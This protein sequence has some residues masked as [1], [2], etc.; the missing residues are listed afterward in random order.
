M[1]GR[2]KKPARSADAPDTALL[3]GLDHLDQGVLVIGADL[4]VRAGNRILYDIYEF[5]EGF[6][7]IGMPMA[8]VFRFLALRGD[9]GPGDPDEITENML[10]L[11]RHGR[12]FNT[13]IR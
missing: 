2:D 8:D 4:M 9:Y 6:I 7:R 11:I 5:P 1:T 10:D 3:S 12:R 13:E